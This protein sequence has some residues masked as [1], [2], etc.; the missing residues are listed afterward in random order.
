[1]VNVALI[2]ANSKYKSK[3][4]DLPK[5]TDDAVMMKEMLNIHDY[6]IEVYPDVE[7]IGNQLENFVKK[8]KVEKIDRLHFHFSGHGVHNALIHLEADEREKMKEMGQSFKTDT[9]V[10]ECL[11]ETTGELYSVHDLNEEKA[12]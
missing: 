10:G 5:V 6:K 3:D 9:P 7:D 12:P 4:H 2:I 11:V 8:C 1:M